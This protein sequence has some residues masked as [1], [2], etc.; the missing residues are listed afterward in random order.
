[1]QL[2]WP[3]HRFR[4]S[5]KSSRPL[6]SLKRSFRSQLW[7]TEF[8]ML[9]CLPWIQERSATAQSSRESLSL[10]VFNW[11]L[12]KLTQCRCYHATWR[13][14]TK[15]QAL[16]LKQSVRFRAKKEHDKP[17]SAPKM[18]KFVLPLRS[19]CVKITWGEIPGTHG[20]K[21]KFPA[22]TI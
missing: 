20:I 22:H 9:H 12:L 13:K 5:K 21:G 16:L 14:E 8:K 2:S 19:S 15:N 18:N 4:L 11:H 17:Q 10:S 1:M 7:R 6:P 3:W